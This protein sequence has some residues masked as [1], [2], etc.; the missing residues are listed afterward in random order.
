MLPSEDT[1]WLGADPERERSIVMHE[2]ASPSD[3]IATK[4]YPHL[5]SADD[6][7]HT[8]AQAH[9]AAEDRQKMLRAM[10]HLRAFAISLSGSIDQADDLV[11]ETILRAL[12]NIDR[13]QP[14]TDMQAWLFTILR[15]QFYTSFRKR[16]REVEDPDGDRK[17]TRLNSSHANISYAVFCF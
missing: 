4:R 1:G 2:T 10:P 16:R 11:Q 5:I 9:V 14:G 7:P 17:S 6:R 15:N 13:F 3:G 12:S 8:P